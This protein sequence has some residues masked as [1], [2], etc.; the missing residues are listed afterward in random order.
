MPSMHIVAPA[1]GRIESSERV[2]TL[3]GSWE[4]AMSAR[5]IP[6]RPTIR[7]ERRG[8]RLQRLGFARHA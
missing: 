6:T 4:S 7:H 3:F 5:A 8:A 2:A 1:Q